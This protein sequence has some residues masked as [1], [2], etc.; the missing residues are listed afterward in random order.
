ML[1]LGGITAIVHKHGSTGVTYHD[2]AGSRFV[3]AFSVT[4]VDPTGAGDCFGG[5]FIALRLRGEDIDRALTVAAAA[6]ALAVTRRGP[7]EGA[8]TLDTLTAFAA[9]QGRPV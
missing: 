2:A 5:A 7:M 4:E 1:G 8:A 6:G 3:P 9:S